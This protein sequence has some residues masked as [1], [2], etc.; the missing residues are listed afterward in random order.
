MGKLYFL[1]ITLFI[2]SFS[3]IKQNPIFLVESIY[4]FVLSTNDNYYYVITMG[5]NLKIIKES[6][7]IEDNS[8]NGAIREN[9]IFISDNSNNNWIY[10]SNSYYKIIYEPFLSYDEFIIDQNSEYRDMTFSGCISK[11]NIDEIIIYGYYQNDH[12]VFSTGLGPYAFLKIDNIKNYKI[13]CI[14]IQNEDYT[15]GIIENRI[16]IGSD[17][18]CRTQPESLQHLTAKPR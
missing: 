16:V 15:C 5:K 18:S 3:Q 13:I 6:G 11:Y 2:Q 14:F 1:F 12:L 17:A 4:P 8:D 9:Y 10:L 7:I